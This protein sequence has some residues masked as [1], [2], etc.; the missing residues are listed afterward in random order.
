VSDD[1]SRDPFQP[2]EPLPTGDPF[3]PAGS[4]DATT[5]FRGAAPA[6]PVAPVEAPTPRPKGSGGMLVNVVLGIALVVAV[7]G[8]AFA[9]G[10]VTAP[11]AAVAPPT[12]FGANGGFGPTASGA[13]GGFTGGLGG[14]AGGVSIEG[15]VTAVTAD[16][17]TVQLASGQSVTIPTDVQTTWHQRE[18]ATAADVTTGSTVIVQLQGGRGAL[19]GNG[20]QG[21]GP[22]A[23]GAPGRALGP[24]STVTLVPAGS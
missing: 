7:G 21:V 15:T 17:I 6:G 20:G 1:R 24:A 19:N 14:L 4:D 12:G 8:V 16:S 3:A 13:P 23:S 22:G 11:A 10:R 2:R 9:A 18:P 5:A